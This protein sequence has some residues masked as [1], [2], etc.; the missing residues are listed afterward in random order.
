MILQA[1]PTFKPPKL[2]PSNLTRSL[3]GIRS[4]GR[5]LKPRSAPTENQLS[6]NHGT[7]IGSIRIYYYI[8]Y[9]YNIYIY[10]CYIMYLLINPLKKISQIWVNVSWCIMEINSSALEN[11]WLGSNSFL[12]RFGLFSGAK[13]RNCYHFYSKGAHPLQQIRS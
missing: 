8:I 7:T 13:L 1:L 2:R 12:L 3:C 9:I 5:H 6:E 11:G 4:Q 10:I